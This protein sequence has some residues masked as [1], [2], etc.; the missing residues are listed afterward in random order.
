M[1]RSRLNLVVDLISALS[2]IALTT[3]GLV[4]YWKLPPGSGRVEGPEGPDRPLTLLWGWDRHEWGALHFGL[5]LLFLAVLSLHVGLH[6]KWLVTMMTRKRTDQPPE[7]RAAL[8]LIGLSLLIVSLLPLAGSSQVKT[9]GQV[10]SERGIKV[11]ATPT[12]AATPAP[13]D[14]ESAY[15]QY[16]AG[17]H[18]P[19]KSLPPLGVDWT[20]ERLRKTPPQAPH[21]KPSE[22]ELQAIFSYVR[23]VQLSE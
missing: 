13:P 17:C 18:G 8:G 14:Q 11:A 7:P 20:P 16:C 5:G 21:Q 15:T 6:W 9:R 2:F 22:E 3:T 10:K 23:A 19:P 12:P 1:K 4:L